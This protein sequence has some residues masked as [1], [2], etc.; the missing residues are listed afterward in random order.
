MCNRAWHFFSFSYM[1]VGSRGR[2]HSH[3]LLM[4]TFGPRA[5]ILYF[6]A[7]NKKRLH[8]Q[9]KCCTSNFLSTLFGIGG[10][11]FYSSFMCIVSYTEIVFA[12][13][14]FRTRFLTHSCM[15]FRC[16]FFCCSAHCSVFAENISWDGWVQGG[17]HCS[18]WQKM[19]KNSCG[20]EMP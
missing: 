7:I 15:Y 18:E 17:T 20:P 11:T 12:H 1:A 8:T 19:F 14:I 13:S 6:S 9:H 3:T 4:S 16:C 5:L 2:G 10:D